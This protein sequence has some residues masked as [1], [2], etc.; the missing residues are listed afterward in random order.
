MNKTLFITAICC[1]LI[2][3][4]F[5]ILAT[6]HNGMTKGDWFILLIFEFC[7]QALWELNKKFIK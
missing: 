1:L 7:L 3:S 6:S 5:N 4:F 2:F